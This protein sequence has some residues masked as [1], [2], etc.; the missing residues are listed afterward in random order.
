MYGLHSHTWAENHFGTLVLSLSF[1]V[2]IFF[3]NTATQNF[4]GTCTM[5]PYKW[6]L[7]VYICLKLW[8]WYARDGRVDRHKSSLLKESQNNHWLTQHLGTDE[9]AESTA[10]IFYH[11]NASVCSYSSN[12]CIHLLTGTSAPLSI[13]TCCAAL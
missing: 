1:L 13:F 10:W 9:S 4:L 7:H 3:F 5:L 11:R 8:Q 2:N 6:S 12:K